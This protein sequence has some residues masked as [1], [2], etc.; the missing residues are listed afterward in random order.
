M[1][2]FF[3]FIIA[4]ATFSIQAQQKH[5][6]IDD[7]VLGYYKGLYPQSL[8]MLQEPISIF[9]WKIMFFIS[10]VPMEK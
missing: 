10:K 2:K 3:L 6:T 8:Q 7:S 1:R 4:L 9:T 5:L